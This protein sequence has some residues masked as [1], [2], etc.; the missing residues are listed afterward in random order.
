MMNVELILRASVYAADAHMLQK[1]KASPEPY[2]NHPLRVAHAAVQA[3][4]P[5]EAIAAALLHDVVEDTDK[6]LDDLKRVFPERVV[7]LVH[8]LTKWWPDDAPKDVKDRG[9]PEYY[10]AI[11]KDQ[12]AMAVK[13]L[14]RAD[15][16]HDMTLMLPRARDWADRYLRKTEKEL[17]PILEG[18]DNAFARDA[19]TKRLE[20]L[21]I[22]LAR[23]PVKP[24]R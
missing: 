6:T 23:T 19:Y 7:H 4:L 14:D 11:L 20:G 17:A 13:L 10:G 15:N 3:G 21:R 22:K 1:R 12:D 2:V 8:L 16:L 9:K 5:A 24:K 18:C